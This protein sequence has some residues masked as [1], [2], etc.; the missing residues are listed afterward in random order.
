MD[1][2][3]QC[4]ATNNAGARCGKYAMRGSTV[5]GS[6]GGR[7][8]QVRK[9]AQERIEREEVARDMVT[10]GLPVDIDPTEALL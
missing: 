3:K 9:A 10:L 1:P 5:C 6:H 8:P 2:A 7:A 4:T